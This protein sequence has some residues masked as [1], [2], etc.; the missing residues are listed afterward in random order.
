VHELARPEL[1]DVVIEIGVVRHAERRADDGVVRPLHGDRDAARE[2][3]RSRVLLT[4]CM[5]KSRQN[6]SVGASRRFSQ[7]K[8]ASSTARP[9]AGGR[10]K[11]CMPGGSRLSGYDSGW[12]S[13]ARGW[14]TRRLRLDTF[15][16][17]M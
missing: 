8:K 9:S 17:L 5:P 4:M 2:S 12:R 13:T 7:R 6:A 14:F 11:D 15:T 10:C 3:R 1:L 16:Q